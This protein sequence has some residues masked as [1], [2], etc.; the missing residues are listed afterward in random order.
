MNR[1]S[2]FSS[3][4]Q[5]LIRCGWVASIFRAWHV[6]G[7]SSPGPNFFGLSG[8]WTRGTS[9]GFRVEEESSVV[10]SVKKGVGRQHTTFT[11]YQKYCLFQ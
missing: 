5:H 6:F 3:V 7:L 2:V 10:L 9:V 1:A 4:K 11:S 8:V